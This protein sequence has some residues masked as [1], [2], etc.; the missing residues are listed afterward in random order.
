MLAHLQVPIGW[1][2]IVRRTFREAFYEDNCLGMA[3]QLAY[4]FFFALFPALLMLIAL[5]SYFPLERLVDDIIAALGGFAP[6][7]VLQVITDQMRKI[8]EGEQGGLF[9][10]G[11]LAALWSSSAAMVAV[12]DTLNRAYDIEEGRPWWKVRLTAIALTVGVALFILAA[13]ALVLVGPEVAEYIAAAT[14][15]GPVFEWTWKIVQWPLVFA[16]ASLG[17]AIIYYFAPD[18]EQDWVWLTPGSIFATT[19]WLITS[20][21]F[22]FYLASLGSYTETYGAI[23]GVMVLLLWFYLSGL[24]ILVGAEMNAEIE[25]ASP[26]GKRPGE[27]TPGEKRRIGPAAMRAWPTRHRPGGHAGL[28]Q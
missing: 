20:L 6:P 16:L 23:G 2:E 5:A 25:H 28:A 10:L 4:Y 7:E 1:G 24:V 15:L 19:L 17:I 27:K 9:T 13:F 21:G 11:M 22:R 14:L 26:Y 12:I 18:A 3:A 8:S